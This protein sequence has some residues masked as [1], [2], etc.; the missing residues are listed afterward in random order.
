MVD[1]PLLIDISWGVYEG[2][3]Y[4]ET[5][6]DEKGGDYMFHPEK[7]IIPEGE[8][9]ININLIKQKI[10]RGNKNENNNIK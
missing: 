6:G 5:F 3:T 9:N 1:E 7:L 10:K 2:K 4:Q 8:I